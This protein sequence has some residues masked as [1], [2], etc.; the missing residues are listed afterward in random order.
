MKTR[1]P[2]KTITI[3]LVTLIGITDKAVRSLAPFFRDDLTYL[4]KEISPDIYS[5]NLIGGKDFFIYLEPKIFTQDLV[6]LLEDFY[7][8][9][10]GSEYE[11][12]REK[13]LN[14]FKELC[15]KGPMTYSVCDHTSIEN[16]KDFM[17][18]FTK[19]H[20]PT[21]FLM[22]TKGI[23]VDCDGYVLRVI[24]PEEATFDMLYSLEKELQEKFSSHPLAK[25]LKVCIEY[26]TDFDRELML[27]EVNN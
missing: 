2:R 14:T 18:V 23:K 17:P 3:Q 7:A 19:A 27:K 8:E 21:P 11:P 12:Q 16:R 10:L 13:V 20:F 22:H 9:Y 15:E 26:D 4:D 1:T 24:P 5:Y 25:A 6:P